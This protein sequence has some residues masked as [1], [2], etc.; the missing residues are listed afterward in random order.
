MRPSGINC[1]QCRSAVKQNLRWPLP[2]A[3]TRILSQFG[4]TPILVRVDAAPVKLR[5]IG[6]ITVMLNFNCALAALVASSL[7]SCTSATSLY[8]VTELV[9]GISTQADAIAKLGQPTSTSKIGGQ[10]VLQWT[11]ANTPVHLA[12]SFGMDGRMIQVA[13]DA[14]GPDQFSRAI[15]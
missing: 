10:T 15:K 7:T 14:T 3:R 12:I 13:S 6:Q 8:R 1:N 11:D 4:H 9:P 5:Q 2:S